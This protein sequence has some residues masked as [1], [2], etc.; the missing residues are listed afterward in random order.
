LKYLRTILVGFVDHLDRRLDA[1][2]GMVKD[3]DRQQQVKEKAEL[4]ESQRQRL[5]IVKR[6]ANSRAVNLSCDGGAN[7]NSPDNC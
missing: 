1:I 6:A 2:V 3:L 4:E 7:E 5:M